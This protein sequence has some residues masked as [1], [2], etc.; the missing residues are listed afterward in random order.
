MDTIS[1]INVA[2]PQWKASCKTGSAKWV[3]DGVCSDA[4]VFA[5]LLGLDGPPTFKTKKMPNDEFVDM[6]GDLTVSVRCVK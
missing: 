4:N 1:L 2:L 5:A 6:I 3:Y